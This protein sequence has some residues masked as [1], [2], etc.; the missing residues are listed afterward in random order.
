MAIS[1]FKFIRLKNHCPRLVFIKWKL[2]KLILKK[3]NYFQNLTI[4]GKF[5][6]QAKETLSTTSKTAR[7]TRTSNPRD[8]SAE[9]HIPPRPI[10]AFKTPSNTCSILARSNRA[11]QSNQLCEKPLINAAPKLIL[12]DQC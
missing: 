10:K 5:T 6:N 3:K 7:I 12:T 11:T 1:L 4:A 9:P 2:V 8:S